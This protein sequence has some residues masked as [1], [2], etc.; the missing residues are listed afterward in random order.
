[1]N[2]LDL[3]V[4]IALEFQPQSIADLSVS[5][6]VW[7]PLLTTF[8]TTQRLRNKGLIEADGDK[9]WSLTGLG[10]QE[11]AKALPEMPVPALRWRQDEPEEH[12][13][14]EGL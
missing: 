12:A 4:L 5:V 14:G 2:P 10:R 7:Q 13:A 1:M 8:M 11:L 3:D 6:G 9:V